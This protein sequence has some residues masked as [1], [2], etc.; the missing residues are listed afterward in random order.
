MSWEGIGMNKTEARA[1]LAL[2]GIRAPRPL[3]VGGLENLFNRHSPK[4]SRQS[5]LRRKVSE[6]VQENWAFL[7]QVLPC[8]GDCASPDNKCPDGQAL[9]CYEKNKKILS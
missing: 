2:A 9:T 3:G 4:H 6:Y 8:Q 5:I 7:S 1:V